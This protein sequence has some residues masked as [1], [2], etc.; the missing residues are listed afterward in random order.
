MLLNI[1]VTGAAGLI[2]GEVCAQLVG[3]GHHVHALVHRRKQVLANDGAPIALASVISGDV[4]QAGLGIDDR[5]A[6]ALKGGLDLIIHCAASLE[7]DAPLKKLNAINVEGTRNV[8]AFAKAC[9]AKLLH[10]STAYVCGEL[11]GPIAE[12][13]VPKNTPFGNSYEASKAAG[14]AVVHKSGLPY[15]I[16]RPSVVMGEAASGQIR[17]FPSICNLFRLLARGS[18]SLL[19]ATENANFDLVPI[20]YVASSLAELAERMD[21]AN[22]GIFHLC[23][24]SPTRVRSLVD[25]LGQFAHFP[26]AKPVDFEAYSPDMLPS[27]QARVMEKMLATFGTYLH[28]DP[29]FSGSNFR[30]L[31]GLKCP[32]TGEDYLLRLISYA[33]KAGY[34]PQAPEPVSGA[35]KTSAISEHQDSACPA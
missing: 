17:E 25:A 19:P 34:L 3:R 31:T 16:V 26:K 21:E 13:P 5:L 9:D 11:D 29:H 32:P 28:R 15:V 27:S 14:E 20:D 1:L 4:T 2:G 8:C 35:S 30:A 6:G 18:I 10:V 33:I 24:A 7:F 23:S 22:R 12:I